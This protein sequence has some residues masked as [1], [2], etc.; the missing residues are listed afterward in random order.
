VLWY[1]FYKAPCGET[2]VQI[3]AGEWKKV[4]PVIPLT[5]PSSAFFLGFSLNLLHQQRGDWLE[6]SNVSVTRRD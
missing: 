1:D 5:P 6:I 3:P 4:V 2:T